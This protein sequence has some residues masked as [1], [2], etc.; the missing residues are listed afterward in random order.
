MLVASTTLF[1]I[2]HNVTYVDL[3]TVLLYGPLEDCSVIL[4]NNVYLRDHFLSLAGSFPGS[5]TSHSAAG[6]TL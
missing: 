3:F 2:I 4:Y 5:C 1:F 6:L